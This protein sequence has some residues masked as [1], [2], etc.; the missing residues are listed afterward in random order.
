MGGSSGSSGGAEQAKATEK[1]IEVQNQQFQQIQAQLAPYTSAGPAALSQLQNL[2]T[3]SGQTSALNDYYGS[4]QYK[5]LQN[6][7]QYAN[8]SAAEATGG[9]GN[10]STSNALAAIAPTLGQQYLSNQMQNYGNLTSIGMAGAS[11][12]GQA[13]TNYANNVTSLYSQLGA[14]QAAQANQPSTASKALT[15]A[16]AGAAAGT[17]IMPGWGTAIGAGVGLVGSLL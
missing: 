2:S 12:T 8:L 1:G 5:Q 9:L 3:L 10:T 14:S 15:G 11:G 16:A 6:Q 4:D 13:S 7:A 17:A